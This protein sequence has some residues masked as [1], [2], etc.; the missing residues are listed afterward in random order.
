MVHSGVHTGLGE[1]ER[2]YT[3]YDASWSPGGINTPPLELGTVGRV[4]ERLRIQVG[5]KQEK[6]HRGNIIFVSIS[7]I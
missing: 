7:I 5:E 1:T 3:C 6:R 2:P 4:G